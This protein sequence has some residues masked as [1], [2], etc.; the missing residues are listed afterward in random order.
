MRRWRTQA[1]E[2]DMQR[3]FMFVAVGIGIAFQIEIAIDRYFDSDPDTDSDPGDFAI[4][5]LFSKW[6]NRLCG[7]AGGS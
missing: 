3:L 6:L 1:H 4:S 7:N 5:G 2:K